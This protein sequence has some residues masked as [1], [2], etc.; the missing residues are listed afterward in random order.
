M[1]VREVIVAEAIET[2]EIKAGL[3]E[4]VV[5]LAIIHVKVGVAEAV[6]G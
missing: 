6:H 3:I 5:N 1:T 4:F 2:A